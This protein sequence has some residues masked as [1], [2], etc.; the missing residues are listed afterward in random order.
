MSIITEEMAIEYHRCSLYKEYIE[1]LQISEKNEGDEFM[2]S[3]RCSTIYV[4]DTKEV[5]EKY[6]KQAADQGIDS[7]SIDRYMP[8]TDDK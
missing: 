1:Q 4:P 5:T 3:L 2:K 8:V 6:R 7:E